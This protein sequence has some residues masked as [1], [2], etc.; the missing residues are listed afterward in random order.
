MRGGESEIRV[1]KKR[2]RMGRVWGESMME[3]KEE[4]RRFRIEGEKV[5]KKRGSV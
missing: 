1:E 2:G 4:G 5:G 3:R